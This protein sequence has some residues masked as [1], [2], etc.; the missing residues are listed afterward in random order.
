MTSVYGVTFVG[1]RQQIQ[2]RLK[3][4]NALPEEMRYRA[5]CYAA[6]STLQGLDEMFTNA[7]EVMDW[8]GEAA[9][10]VATTGDSVR[11]RTPLGLP[12]LQPYRRRGR[13]IVKTIL[14][15][16]IVEYENDTLPVVKQKQ[17]SAFP[18]NYV[19]SI[20]SSH[21]MLTALEC[22]QRGLAFA[23]VHD[24]FWT[25]AG[26]VPIMNEV[27]RD[28]FV[29]LHS[30]L[31]LETLHASLEEDFPAI[32]GQLPPPPPRGDLD[33]NLVKQSPYFFS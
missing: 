5:A 7:R 24:S 33:L 11:W 16:F 17:K 15:N 27:L 4:R 20:D 31:L 30:E 3:E 2:A 1:A 9:S 21:M 32:R 12:V 8:L 13:K 18:P 25:H 26:T 23:G 19:H 29:E 28:K 6:R 22:K 10:I 14:Q